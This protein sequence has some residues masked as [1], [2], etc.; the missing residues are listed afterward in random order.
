MH[1]Y[2]YLFDLGEHNE[3]KFNM[4]YG[5]NKG[6]GK[7]IKYLYDL[8]HKGYLLA[9]R[10]ASSYILDNKVYSSG[11]GIDR[12]SAVNV[13]TAIKISPK[14]AFNVALEESRKVLEELGQEKFIWEYD[15]FKRYTPSNDEKS[16][17][18]KMKL[19]KI[20]N[21][22]YQLV[23]QFEIL[24]SLAPLTS[25]EFL[26]DAKKGELIKKQSTVN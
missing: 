5:T 12:Y 7:E 16:I 9:P 17:K 14:E 10:I 20:D 1:Y 6:N 25:F 22:Q 4:K 15:D 13:D 19:V 3:L 11:N 23:Y 24:I 8:Y 26:I 2:G 18:D 21:L